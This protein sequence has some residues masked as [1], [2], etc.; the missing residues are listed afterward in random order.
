MAVSRDGS[1]HFRP[2][3]LSD[4]ISLGSLERL[5]SSDADAL[6]TIEMDE[7][8][9]NVA[10]PPSAASSSLYWPP[11]FTP[12]PIPSSSLEQL[13]NANLSA[14]ETSYTVAGATATVVPISETSSIY[15]H[16]TPTPSNMAPLSLLD[17]CQ[18]TGQDSPQPSSIVV[19]DS[20]ANSSPDQDPSAFAQVS[21][22]LQD[23]QSAYTGEE[24][25]VPLP[26]SV[27][28]SSVS[29][30]DPTW[31]LDPLQ[32]SAAAAEFYIQLPQSTES[33]HRGNKSPPAPASSP[34]PDH[35]AA[36]ADEQDAEASYWQRVA[37]LL[38]RLP[39]LKH[40][41][42]TQG[43]RH[44]S[45]GSV[46][47]LDH[48]RNGSSARTRKS[49]EVKEM[50]STEI[51]DTVQHLRSVE[52]AAVLLR[53]LIVE[54]L[55]PD[56]ME[57]L[58]STFELDPEFF[59]HHLSRSGYAMADYDDLP[60]HRW[61]TFGMPCEHLSIRWLRPMLLDPHVA[62]WTK[63]PAALLNQF[64]THSQGRQRT[65]PSSV[66]WTDTEFNHDGDHNEQRTEHRWA[67]DTNIFRRSWSLFTRPVRTETSSKTSETW[68]DQGNERVSICWKRREESAPELDSSTI[69]GLDFH[70]RGWVPTA[71]EEK[72][73]VFVYRGTTVPICKNVYST[74]LRC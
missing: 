38:D 33:A 29:V 18:S 52:D 53:V 47:C 72:V 62:Q 43:C 51:R 15:R 59:A 16:P 10:L 7:N 54:D 34:I 17:G 4:A 1:P 14:L 32:N 2:R 40:I 31:S 24:Y 42:H 35:D 48:M 49:F 57:A 20:T 26:G 13:P 56:L 36:G 19:A 63:S 46:K 45:A 71:W 39:Y 64:T 73:S 11:T 58:G 5:Q 41:L 61:P 6:R 60:P 70:R 65:V 3:S 44:R 27:T 8:A 23:V 21:R 74:Q 28:P 25:R 69:H 37:P 68:N 66:T 9:G 30:H 50:N 12:S 67:V 55:S 22:S